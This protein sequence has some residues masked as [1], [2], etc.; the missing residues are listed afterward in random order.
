VPLVVEPADGIVAGLFSRKTAETGRVPDIYRTLAHQPRLLQAWVD[1]AF[2]LRYEVST[3][4]ALRELMILR[5]AHLRGA[6]HEWAAHSRFAA[7]AGL[8]PAEIAAVREWRTS[9]RFDESERA[10]LALVDEMTTA[11]HVTDA[12]FEAVAERF[13]TSEIVELVLT[14]G[15]YQ[16]VSA[17]LGAFEPPS[18]GDQPTVAAT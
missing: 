5:V 1:M 15:F 2:P 12:T 13:A 16:C 11:N 17:V 9:D 7:D 18:G 14:V 10:C 3:S 6:A 4:R 8:S